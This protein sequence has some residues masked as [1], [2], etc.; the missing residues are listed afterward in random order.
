MSPT[1]SPPQPANIPTAAS[2]PP[3]PSPSISEDDSDDSSNDNEK[4]RKKQKNLRGFTSFIPD[5]DMTTFV[6][7]EQG[8]GKIMKGAVNKKEKKGEIKPT[9]NKAKKGAKVFEV[10]S[11]FASDEKKKKTKLPPNKESMA[12]LPGHI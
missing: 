4:T 11:F 8:Y 7:K 9:S 12:R 3:S 1:D 2:P 10:R 5:K 6:S